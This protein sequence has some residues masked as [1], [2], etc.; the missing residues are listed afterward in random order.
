[1]RFS[2]RVWVGQLVAQEQEGPTRTLGMEV[3]FWWAVA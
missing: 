2:G 1:M 3:G